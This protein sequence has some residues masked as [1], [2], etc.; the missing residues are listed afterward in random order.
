MLTGI[1]RL[2][3]KA[4]LKIKEWSA[5]A[6]VED[7]KTTLIIILF[8]LLLILAASA[9][10]GDEVKFP[11]GVMVCP[12]KID[13]C[14]FCLEVQSHRHLC[15]HL[16]I[17]LDMKGHVPSL[18]GVIIDVGDDPEHDIKEVNKWM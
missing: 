12:D 17:G 8:G 9:V 13:T 16:P 2:A 6:T 14:A 18:P 3:N 7:F 10:R 5:T 15:Y 4:I 1:K 11:P